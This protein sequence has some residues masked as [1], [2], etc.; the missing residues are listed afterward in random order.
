MVLIWWPRVKRR[1]IPIYLFLSRTSLWSGCIPSGNR[2]VDL[3]LYECRHGNNLSY[4]NWLESVCGRSPLPWP[5]QS[6]LDL[7]GIQQYYQECFG[8][9]NTEILAENFECIT[10]MHSS[11]MCTVRCS[12]RPGGCIPACTGQ[13]GICPVHAGIHPTPCEQNDRRLWKHNLAA[14]TLRTVII[15]FVQQ[16]GFCL[17]AS[18]MFFKFNKLHMPVT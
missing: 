14:T 4:V 2:P 12:G 17:G 6:L 18:I 16:T 7:V 15:I 9:T 13:G 8:H 1:K 5:W 10:R 3:V 11:R